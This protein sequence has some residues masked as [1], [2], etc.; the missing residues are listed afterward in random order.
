MHQ[1][2]TQG[3]VRRIETHD[4]HTP[5]VEFGN[6]Q[7]GVKIELLR[8][9]KDRV[10]ERHRFTY[11][12]VAETLIGHAIIGDIPFFRW[13]RAIAFLRPTASGNSASISIT[14]CLQ[15][16]SKDLGVRVIISLSHIDHG[17]VADRMLPPVVKAKWSGTSCV[18]SCGIEA[19]STTWQ[20]KGRREREP[21]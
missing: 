15:G 10:V 21:I 14:T 6:D 7:V 9:H 18:A 1:G 2:G 4:R 3:K 13:C 16:D 19:V 12:S 11:P 17:P 8:E 5:P 20:D